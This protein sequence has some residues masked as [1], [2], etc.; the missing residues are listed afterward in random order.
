MDRRQ[1][2]LPHEQVTEALRVR[3]A[4]QYRIAWQ[5]EMARNQ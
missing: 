2:Q 1:H 5:D 3:L 4:G